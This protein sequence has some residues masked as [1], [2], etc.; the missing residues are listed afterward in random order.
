MDERV[1]PSV[2]ELFRENAPELLKFLF[3][4]DLFWKQIQSNTITET[5]LRGHQNL[6]EELGRTPKDSAVLKAIYEIRRFRQSV[7]P[8]PIEF[9]LGSTPGN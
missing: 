3:V 5:E 6:L 8:T 4:E 2:E 7:L 1:Q 9:Y